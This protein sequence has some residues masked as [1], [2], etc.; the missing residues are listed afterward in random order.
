[1]EGLLAR[2]LAGDRPALA[3]AITLAAAAPPGFAPAGALVGSRKAH[4]VGITGPPGVGKSTLIGGLIKLWRERGLRV[5]VVA[6]DPA[7]PHTGG[8]FLGDRMRMAPPAADGGVFIRS[9]AS[10]G[11]AAELPPA[12]VAAADLLDAAGFERV[13][14]E[15]VGAGQNDVGLKRFADTVVVVLSPECGDEYQ[16]LKAGLIETADILVVNRADRPGAEGWTRALREEVE[17]RPRGPVAVVPTS[18]VSGEGLPALLQAIE[19]RAAG[20]SVQ[21]PAATGRPVVEKNR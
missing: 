11:P 20:K 4:R 13:V 9:L 7:S 10:R 3:R 5:A 12:A 16:L 14:F 18:A 2:L 1:M 15:T 8:A 19:A 21:E 17:S 6:C